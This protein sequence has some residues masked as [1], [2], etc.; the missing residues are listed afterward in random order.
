MKDILHN[1]LSL[2]KQV[3]NE[4]DDVNQYT[5]SCDCI[6]NYLE[7][8][9]YTDVYITREKVYYKSGLWEV[10]DNVDFVNY[11]PLSIKDYN[12][13]KN[14]KCNFLFSSLDNNDSSIYAVLPSSDIDNYVGTWDNFSS[15]IDSTRYYIKLYMIFTNKINY[16][17]YKMKSD[18]EVIYTKWEVKL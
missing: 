8:S 13:I 11:C 12:K 2:I 18:L 14:S 16:I 4:Y 5:L 15:L 17:K 9:D 10:Q 1:S 3:L 6:S 7:L